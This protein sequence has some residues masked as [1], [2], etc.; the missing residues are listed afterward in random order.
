M[1]NYW[2]SRETFKR[3]EANEIRRALQG[4]Y[5]TPLFFIYHPPIFWRFYIAPMDCAS[6][7][8]P[9]CWLVACCSECSQPLGHCT[10][11]ACRHGWIWPLMQFLFQLDLKLNSET[12]GDLSTF[13]P[14]G[15]WEVIG[16]YIQL[17]ILMAKTERNQDSAPDTAPAA[18]LR[19]S[20]ERN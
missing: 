2:W 3:S 7:V 16:N 5:P 13:I 11:P 8:N 15:E 14:N 4:W 6:A 17:I 10:A 18:V 12:G 1:G 20:L 9:K 19:K